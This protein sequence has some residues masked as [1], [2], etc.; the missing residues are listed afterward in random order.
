[1]KLSKTA[2]ILS[3]F[4]LAITLCADSVSSFLN[5]TAKYDSRATVGPGIARF[6][7]EFGHQL[8]FVQGTGTG[9]ETIDAVYAMSGTVTS[10]TTGIY[11]LH[12]LTD[13][14]GASLSF[15][16]VKIFGVRNIST[17]DELTVGMDSWLKTTTLG[18]AG[19]LVN[20]SPLAGL[21]VATGT[22][23]VTISTTATSTA[24][25]IFIAGI[26]N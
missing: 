9:T 19:S 2:L 11:D 12:D 14:R 10:S 15:R 22:D 4:A 8:N 7:G 16:L 18:L 23:I 25:E 3:F 5:I 26:K 13:F 1:M 21:T 6:V 24:Y 20:V 17:A